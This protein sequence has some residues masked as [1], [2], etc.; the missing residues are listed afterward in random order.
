[1]RPI[2]LD[3]DTLILLS[4]L[5][6]LDAFV[7][8]FDA[9]I[10]VITEYE[11]LRGEIKAGIDPKE[12]KSSLELAFNVL[13]FDNKSITIAG[14][15]WTDLSSKGEIIDERDLIIGAICI[16]NNTPLWTKNVRH[17][18]RLKRFGLKLVDIDTETWRIS[19][20]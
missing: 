5:R 9:C 12:S 3:T 4:K 17:F 18:V 2:V 6:K 14:K 19:E 20:I 8:K 1:M 10:T 15:I 11:Y 16:T 7:S 13:S